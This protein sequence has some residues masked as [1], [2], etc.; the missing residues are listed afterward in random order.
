MIPQSVRTHSSPCGWQRGRGLGCPGSPRSLY[1]S[2]SIV[3][4][5]LSQ[6]H[7]FWQTRRG[8]RGAP[9]QQAGALYLKGPPA[10]HLSSTLQKPFLSAESIHPFLCQGSEGQWPRLW[11]RNGGRKVA[12]SNPSLQGNVVKSP[13]FCLPLASHKHQP[14]TK[15]PAH[16][17][18]Q[19]PGHAE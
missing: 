4:V 12:L 5:R 16:S 13:Q 11:S 6:S 19:S 2:G 3:S 15:L 8:P 17:P 18:E 10:S 9:G 7:S 1:S 14:Q